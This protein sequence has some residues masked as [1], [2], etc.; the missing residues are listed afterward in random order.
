[1][2]GKG[3]FRSFHVEDPLIR[4]AKVG[5][6]ITEKAIYAVVTPGSGIWIV[7]LAQQ[8]P[9]EEDRKPR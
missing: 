7:G 5:L 1:M 6:L 4:T 8:T 3:R 9:S 2:V